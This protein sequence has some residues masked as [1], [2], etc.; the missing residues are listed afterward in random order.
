MLL[1]VPTTQ[2][3][4]HSVLR[5]RIVEHL[6]VGKLLQTLWSVG[7]TSVEILRSE[8]DRGGYDLVADFGSVTRHVQLKCSIVG[9]S[10]ADQKISLSMAAKPAGCV[11]WVVVSPT[12]EFDHFLWFGGSP[13]ESLPEIS[14]FRVAK[15]VKA[16]A[17]GVKAE[18]NN[19]RKVSKS[20]FTWVEDVKGILER[21]FGPSWQSQT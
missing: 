8:Y 14:D 15:H 10:A 2:H 12:L 9:A 18:R 19:L 4:L 7:N 1:D 6:L 20:K 16:N 21:L 3:S 5:E 11:I 13:N 17:Q